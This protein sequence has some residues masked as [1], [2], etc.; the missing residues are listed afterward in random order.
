MI[1]FTVRTK[2]WVQYS[3][4][5]WEEWLILK[6]VEMFY[7][8]LQVPHQVQSFRHQVPPG[9]RLGPAGGPAG[10]GRCLPRF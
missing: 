2:G 10:L 6:T 8:L 7:I 3:Y 5:S 4:L 9:E 1:I